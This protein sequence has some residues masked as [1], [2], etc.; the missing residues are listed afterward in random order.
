LI[1]KV[2]SNVV[3][4]IAV[5]ASVP[6]SA[7]AHEGHSHPPTPAPTAGDSR[8]APKAEKKA[9][10]YFVQV[11]DVKEGQ[12][13]A[14]KDWF[15]KQGGPALAAYPGVVS[16]ETYVDEISPGPLLKTIIGFE[17]Y[18]AL[19]RW[20][21]DPKMGKAMEPL[22]SLV[23][24]HKHYIFRSSPLYRAKSLSLPEAGR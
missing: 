20:Y 12:F 18:P 4:L 19:D 6:L 24:P 9:T 1:N 3:A 5:A 10:I 14:F 2:H 22:D 15:Q 23:G 13:A 8:P 11:Y 21:D 7:W 16:V 17:D